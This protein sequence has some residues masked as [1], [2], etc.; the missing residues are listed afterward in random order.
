M[1]GS[2]GARH[3]EIPEKETAARLI[4]C[5]VKGRACSDRNVTGQ[6]AADRGNPPPLTVCPAVCEAGVS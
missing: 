6:A 3:E 1:T 4:I 5:T 2:R